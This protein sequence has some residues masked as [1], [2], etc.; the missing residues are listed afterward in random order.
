MQKYILKKKIRANIHYS[1]LRV[2]KKRSENK[3]EKEAVRAAARNLCL[4]FFYERSPL[5]SRRMINKSF[6]EANFS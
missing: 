5:Q 3:V 2:E 1:K 4:L 6:E